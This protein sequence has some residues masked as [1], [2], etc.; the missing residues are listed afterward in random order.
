MY[1]QN[2]QV[3]LIKYIIVYIKGQND[4]SYFIDRVYDL[5]AKYGNTN[6]NTSIFINNMIN[7]FN[8]QPLNFETMNFTKEN[9]R[10]VWRIDGIDNVE[11]MKEFSRFLILGNK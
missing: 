9:A 2:L 4:M 11:F 3:I 6:S 7:Q 5:K 10:S 1:A 8:Y